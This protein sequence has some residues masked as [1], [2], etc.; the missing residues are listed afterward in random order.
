MDLWPGA[1]VKCFGSVAANLFLPTSDVDM[2]VFGD[3]PRIPLRTL[4]RV[5]DLVSCPH[6]HCLLCVCVCF[7][8]IGIACVGSAHRVPRCLTMFPGASPYSKVLHHV[9]RCCRT[10]VKHVKQGLPLAIRTALQLA[11]GVDG[12]ASPFSLFQMPSK[13][14]PLPLRF[15]RYWEHVER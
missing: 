6:H 7:W 2:V 5:R 11:A 1:T 9:T 10:I 15:T 12:R 14:F 8:H 4:A 13:T 3:W